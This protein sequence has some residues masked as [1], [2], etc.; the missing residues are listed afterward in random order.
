MTEAE[1]KGLIAPCGL[2]C[3][4]C[5]IRSAVARGDP[6]ELKQF[7]AGMALYVGH[8]VEVEDLACDGCLS[9]VLSAPCRVC[10]LRD[11]AFLRGITHCAQCADFPCQQIT[12]FNNDAFAHHTGVLDNIRRQQEIGLEAWAEEQRKRWMCPTCG[13]RSDWYSAECPSCGTSLEGHC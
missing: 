12:D 10:E 3:G 2:Y 5:I 9:E 8:P 7:A 11:C 6:E 4:A 1:E 13:T